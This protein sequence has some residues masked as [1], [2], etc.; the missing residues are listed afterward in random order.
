MKTISLALFIISSFSISRH[1]QS[2]EIE[3]SV[4][5]QKTEA[6]KFTANTTRII[7]LKSEG[8]IL[9]YLKTANDQQ[10]IKLI[11]NNADFEPTKMFPS[12]E[13]VADIENLVYEKATGTLMWTKQLKLNL[14][15]PITL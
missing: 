11:I 8:K 3:S 5:Q 15:L 13:H 4:R 6:V 9:M 7:N 1:A 14:Y 10:A 12:G 2:A